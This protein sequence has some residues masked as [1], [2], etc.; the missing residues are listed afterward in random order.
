MN[1]LLLP[2]AFALM[3]L[4]SACGLKPVVP[5][6]VTDVQFSGIDIFRGTVVMD[7]GLEINNQN[8]FAITIHGMELNVSIDSI[9]MG[10]AS[11]TDKIRIAK[12]TQMVYRIKVQAKLTDLIHGIPAVM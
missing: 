8:N 9:P 1:K 10:V 11:I 3:I 7:M 5:T 6:R 2:G 12:D 4:L